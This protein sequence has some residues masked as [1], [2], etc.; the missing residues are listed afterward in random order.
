VAGISKPNLPEILVYPCRSMSPER[1]RKSISLNGKESRHL[2]EN[3]DPVFPYVTECRK[4]DTT[5]YF[6]LSWAKTL[7]WSNTKAL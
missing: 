7:N 6:Y 5:G 4:T 1:L 3:S 2:N